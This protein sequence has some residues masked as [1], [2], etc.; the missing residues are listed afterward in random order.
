MFIIY[1]FLMLCNGILFSSNN[2]RQKVQDLEPLKPICT[3]II[4]PPLDKNQLT[5]RSSL[6]KEQ[7]DELGNEYMRKG[8]QNTELFR[9]R[10]FKNEQQ[11]NSIIKM[12]IE[13]RKSF[14]F[15]NNAFGSRSNA[16]FSKKHSTW[17]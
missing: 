16:I 4:C 9:L 17:K 15:F 3:R 14:A 6:T 13:Q 1:S 11:R 8:F 7:R 2:F 12:I 5:R 10:R